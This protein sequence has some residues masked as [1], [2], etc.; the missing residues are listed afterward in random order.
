M[1]LHLTNITGFSGN[2]Y[3]EPLPVRDIQFRIR[4]PQEPA[5]LYSMRQEREIPYQWENGYLNFT[6]DEL[7]A[8]EGLIIPVK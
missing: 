5:H 4:C 2:T 3:F 6:V 8:Y 1:I 7:A